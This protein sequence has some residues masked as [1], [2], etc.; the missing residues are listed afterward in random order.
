M[1]VGMN[2]LGNFSALSSKLSYRRAELL[3]A[4]ATM[5]VTFDLMLKME[6]LYIYVTEYYR[7]SK[8]QR[9]LYDRGLTLTLKS[10][11]ILGLA[12]DIAIIDKNGKFLKEDDTKMYG[13]LG[14]WWESHGGV[15]G[16]RWKIGD[17]HDVYHFQHN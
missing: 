10:K 2:R 14:S 12:F 9:E 15:W 1:N 8:R 13:I 11:H 3:V 4:F 16:G 17:G 5:L 7:S 6:G